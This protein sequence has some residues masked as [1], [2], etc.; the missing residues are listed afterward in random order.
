MLLCLI[1]VYIFLVALREDVERERSSGSILRTFSPV[2]F[3]VFSSAVMTA[4]QWG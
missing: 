1:V 4:N 3:D 2:P